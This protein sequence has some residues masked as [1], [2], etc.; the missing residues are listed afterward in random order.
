MIFKDDHDSGINMLG[1]IINILVFFAWR[2]CLLWY[3]TSI[4]GNPSAIR[5]SISGTYGSGVTE[6]GDEI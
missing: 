1:K 5:L 6:N 2:D 4:L 3:E